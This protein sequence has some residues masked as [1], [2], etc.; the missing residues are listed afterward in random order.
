MKVNSPRHTQKIRV[1]DREFGEPAYVVVIKHFVEPSFASRHPFHLARAADGLRI[2]SHA[3]DNE[4]QN[5]KSFEQAGRLKH[6]GCGTP[7]SIRTCE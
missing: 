3:T 1:L 6:T 4:S 7:H 5:T 2:S